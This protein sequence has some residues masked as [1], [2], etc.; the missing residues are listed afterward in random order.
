MYEV[1]VGLNKKL[2]S[3]CIVHS[4]RYTEALILCASLEYFGMDGPN[5]PV[6]NHTYE[7]S[8]MD[9]ESYFKTAV[10]DLLNKYAIFST[11]IPARDKEL[12]CP[13]CPKTYKRMASLKKHLRTKHEGLSLEKKKQPQDPLKDC[14]QNYC[15]SSFGLCLLACDFTDARKHGNGGRILLLYKFMLFHFKAVGK[16]KYAYQILRLFAQTKCLLSPRMAHQLI[17]NRFINLKGKID[18]NVE[19]DRVMEHK[20]KRFK[21]ECRGFHGKIT[22]KS[23]ERVGQAAHSLDKILHLADKAAEVHKSS[24]KHTKVSAK[25]DVLALLTR[26]HKE[27]IFSHKP[28]RKLHA[29]PDFTRNPLSQLDPGSLHTWMTDTLKKLSKLKLYRV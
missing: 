29:F 1:L 11:P 16:S 18:T 22:E 3:F 2:F 21:Q 26:M 5:E 8:S 28:G 7:M 14:V 23:V 20:N 25:D 12:K 10:G 15:C 19:M 24:G 4:F 6:C 17:W 27:G 13:E 9:K